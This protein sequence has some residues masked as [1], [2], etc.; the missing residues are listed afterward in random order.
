[1]TAWQKARYADDPDT[2][3]AAVEAMLLQPDDIA[4]MFPDLSEQESELATR[5]VV[6]M[7][8]W[9]SSYAWHHEI[10]ALRSFREKQR[11]RGRPREPVNIRELADNERIKEALVRLPADVPVYHLDVDHFRRASEWFFFVNERWVWMDEFEEG[12]E[13]FTE[14]NMTEETVGKFERQLQERL[15]RFPPP[16]E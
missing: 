4:V 6:A 1:M 9:A 13:S 16:A 8:L 3:V 10:D 11:E 14:E 12:I 15:K 2:R 7:R 5:L